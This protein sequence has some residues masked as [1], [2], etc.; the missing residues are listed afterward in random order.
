MKNLLMVKITTLCFLLSACA[1]PDE[2]PTVSFGHDLTATETAT[3]ARPEVSLGPLPSLLPEDTLGSE[4][5]DA[6]MG[7]I[8]MEYRE[9]ATRITDRFQDYSSARKDMTTGTGEAF[10]KAWLSAQMELT[11]I[12]QY[13]EDLSKMRARISALGE[14]LPE[15]GRVLLARLEAQEL[16]NR[17]F[18]RE[19]KLALEAL[20][21]SS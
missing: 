20:E 3:T 21:P 9:L 13:T 17:L 6:Y 19:E 5:S 10:T 16:Q 14:P 7:T 18:I 12:S 4:N 8:T 11:N 1:S 2:W 15:K